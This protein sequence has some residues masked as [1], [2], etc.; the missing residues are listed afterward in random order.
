[1]KHLKKYISIILTASLLTLTACS[2][3]APESPG[4]VTFAEITTPETNSETALETITETDAP[5]T[6]SPLTSD[7]YFKY[8]ADEAPKDTEITY[9]MSTEDEE[10]KSIIMGL[11]DKAEEFIY[12]IASPYEYITLR[13]SDG[14]ISTDDFKFYIDEDEYNSESRECAHLLPLDIP[15]IANLEELRERLLI[16]FSEETADSYLDLF[17]VRCEK[18]AEKNDKTF[19]V[20]PIDDGRIDKRFIEMNGTL[21]TGVG[22]DSG[23]CSEFKK[24]RVLEKNESKIRFAYLTPIKSNGAISACEGILINENGW[25]FGWY[26]IDDNDKYIDFNSTW[27]L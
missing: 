9:N 24:I 7:K 13:T 27:L 5:T 2:N 3:I 21:Y 25:K 14:S 6:A 8:G 11:Y 19:L 1:M 26:C 22:Q 12:H 23:I 20:K 4:D 15:N 10:V 16:C 18:L 17:T